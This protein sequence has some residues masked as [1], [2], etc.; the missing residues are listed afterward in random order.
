MSVEN[1]KKFYEVVSR[2]ESMKQKFVELS[3][4]YQG[5]Q[6]DEA[7]AMSV[8]EQE[9]LP[10]AAQRG[11][12]FTMDDL[13]AYGEEMKQA[14]MNCELSDEEMQAVAGGDGG[15]YQC[16]IIGVGQGDISGFCFIYGEFHGG[17]NHV[18]CFIGGQGSLY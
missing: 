12:S 11:Y 6:M 4:K 15:A 18:S 2:D 10:M 8:M 9:G 16:P 3:R 7:K 13:K 14:N 5:Q 1:V 17:R